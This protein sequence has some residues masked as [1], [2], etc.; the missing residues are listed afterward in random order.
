M[1]WE[2][3]FVMPQKLKG[4][5]MVILSCLQKRNAA[6]GASET[7]LVV[8]PKW[9]SEFVV[10][11][12]QRSILKKTGGLHCLQV[13]QVRQQDS[14]CWSGP[15]LIEHTHRDQAGGSRH[16]VVKGP[17]T[18]LIAKLWLCKLQAAFKQSVFSSGEGGSLLQHRQDRERGLHRGPHVS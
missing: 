16:T 4:T 18:G 12:Q 15:L 5:R 2:L 13:A 7:I 3:W 10:F 11:C 1:L 6:Q 14:D 9:Q 17:P 8:C